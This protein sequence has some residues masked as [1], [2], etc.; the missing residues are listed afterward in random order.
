[1]TKDM[2]IFKS[3]EITQEGYNLILKGVFSDDFQEWLEYFMCEELQE[4]LCSF[5]NKRKDERDYEESS[6]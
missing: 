4:V 5:N 1:M 3:L 6:L 2:R